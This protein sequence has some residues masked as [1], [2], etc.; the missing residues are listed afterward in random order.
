[1]ADKG[2]T[3]GKKNRKYGRNKLKCESYRRRVGKPN[4][5]GVPGNKA[6]KN[7]IVVGSS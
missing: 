2:R 7:H 4:G 3:G 1:M 5:P 6:G